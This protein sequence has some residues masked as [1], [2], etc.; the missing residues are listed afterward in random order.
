MRDTLDA[1]PE[2][3]KFRTEYPIFNPFFLILIIVQSKLIFP[4]DIPRV[5]QPKKNVPSTILSLTQNNIIVTRASLFS[6]PRIRAYPEKQ[7]RRDT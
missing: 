4:N 1:Y 7:K 2:F 3:V 6:N 5:F